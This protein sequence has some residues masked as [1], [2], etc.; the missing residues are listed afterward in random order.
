SAITSLGQQMGLSKTEAQN[1]ANQLTTFPDKE[2]QFKLDI[3]QAQNGL[4]SVEQAF[5]NVAKGE[6]KVTVTAVTDSAR[7]ALEEPG[8]KVK[9]LGNGKVEVT[10]NTDTAKAA[11][12]GLQSVVDALQNKKASVQVS[13]DQVPA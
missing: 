10:A 7:A 4:K 9:D 1:L 12:T 13:A 3:A 6:K 5:N 11:R 8:F 2:E